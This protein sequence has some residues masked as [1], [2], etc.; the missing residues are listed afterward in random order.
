MVE[1]LELEGDV[2]TAA[3][4][5]MLKGF[6]HTGDVPKALALLKKMC[7]VPVFEERFAVPPWYTYWIHFVARDEALPNA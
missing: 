3:Y 6:G 1:K 5:T 7:T 4:S 2:S